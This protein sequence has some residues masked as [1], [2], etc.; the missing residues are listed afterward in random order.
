M[1]K[2]LAK[3]RNCLRHDL[4]VKC[5]DLS[6]FESEERLL[7]NDTTSLTHIRTLPEVGC[8]FEAAF[9]RFKR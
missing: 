1:V 3:Q 9:S 2:G 7:P 8:N 5:V 6:L 4:P